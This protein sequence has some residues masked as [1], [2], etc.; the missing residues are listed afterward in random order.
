M[1]LRLSK[2]KVNLLTKLIVDYLE[3]SEEVDYNEDIGN[4]RLKTYRIIMDELKLFED[5]ENQSREKIVSQKKNVP[6]GSREW[7]ILFRKYS[8]EEINK[9]G[10]IW[11]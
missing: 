10:K 1:S 11:D 5:I 4:I 3:K 8:T 9:L 6:E 2:N 7:E